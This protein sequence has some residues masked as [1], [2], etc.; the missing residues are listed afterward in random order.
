VRGTAS[1]SSF[2]HVRPDPEFCDGTTCVIEDRRAPFAQADCPDFL[3]MDLEVEIA[4]TDGAV[5]AV[6]HGE[7]WQWNDDPRFYPMI[8]ED[9][10]DHAIGDAYANLYDVTGSLTLHPP[11]G[12][13]GGDAGPTAVQGG[14]PFPG[15]LVVEI[16][17]RDDV[18][19][20]SIWPAIW[21]EV[22]DEHGDSMLE[23][24]EPLMGRF[25]PED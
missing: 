10:A 15:T 19:H 7:L 8:G 23:T 22:L 13:V 4:T 14:H 1:I 21:W 24:Y 5:H 17:L 11:D 20:G 9:T 16:E 3:R 6:A 25:P 2:E 12:A 18:T